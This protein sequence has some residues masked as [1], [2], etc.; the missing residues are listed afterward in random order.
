MTMTDL[1]PSVTARSTRGR[2][3]IFRPLLNGEEFLVS[4]T[5]AKV[6]CAI[7]SHDTASLSC[8]SSELT[9]T[10]G[11]LNKPLSFLYG[12]APRTETFC[13]YIVD[14]GETQ[15]GQGNITFDIQVFGVTQPMQVGQPR[16]WVNRTIPSAL[17]SVV[18][19]HKLG[20]H[21]HN[22]DFTWR[23]LAQTSESDWSLGNTLV[24][25]LNWGL[26]NRYGVV[27]C[28][29][30]LKLLQ[31]QGVYASL[32]SGKDQDFDPIADRRLIEFNPTETS[33]LV[34]KTLGH[35][36]AYFTDSGQVQIVKEIGSFQKYTFSSSKVI[37]NAEEANLYVDTRSEIDSWKQSALA[38]MWG[39][40]DIYPG[41][42]VE[43]TTSNARYLRQKFD[44][45]WLVV[46]TTHSMDAQQY[47]TMLALRR[48][49]GSTVVTQSPYQSFWTA[50]QR[51]RPTLSIVNDEWVSS[52]ANPYVGSV[53]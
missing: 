24:N 47:Q 13:G 28:Y 7:G 36:L 16:F 38:R 33:D 37:R 31:D 53:L 51:P 43:V 52:W 20:F 3:P 44:G 10:D 8:K 35:K 19:S 48:P 50:A 26:F 45:R 1:L 39:D 14:V 42:C 15:A 23:A 40:A 11:L 2:V 30:P 21:Y 32:V 34:P 22:H 29:D 18:S 27:M 17:E 12:Q 25:R 9:T 5:G 49:G 4:F 6:I 41:M 46:G